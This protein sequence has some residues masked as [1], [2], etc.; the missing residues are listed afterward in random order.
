M[1]SLLLKQYL[2]EVAPKLKK[3]FGLKNDLQVPR[4]EKIV[5]NVGMGSYLQKIGKKDGAEVVENVA[6]ITGQKPVIKHA[7]MSVSNFKLREGMPVGAMV[8]LRGNQAYNF[9]DKL[10]N[11]VYPRVRGFVSSPRCH[12]IPFGV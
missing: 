4:I 9:L 12:P 10:I 6:K 2:E 7:R 11:I 5:V 8:T 1:K 3:E